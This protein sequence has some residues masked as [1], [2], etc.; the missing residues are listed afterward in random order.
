[1]RC[2]P[3]TIDPSGYVDFLNDRLA[4]GRYDAVLPVHDQ[5]YLLSRVPHRLQVPT[6]LPVPEFPALDRLQSKAN[7]AGVLAELGLPHPPPPPTQIV[8]TPAELVSACR[9]PCY[10]KQA[11]GTA[12]QGVWLVR[13]GEELRA[14]IDRLER[15]GLL[16]G[17]SEVLVQQPAVG[18]LGV[19]QTVFQH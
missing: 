12:G 19:V 5:V 6:G 3:F 15:A 14:V 17:E 10:V 8:R 9:F 18:T 13:D 1:F 2:P 11:Y 7:L 16:S 4:A